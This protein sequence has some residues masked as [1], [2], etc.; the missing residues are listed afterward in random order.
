MTSTSSDYDTNMITLTRHTLNNQHKH[1]EANGD[2][3]LL[4]ASVQLGC[5]FVATMVRKAGLA[6]LY[7]NG[8][9]SKHE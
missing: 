5:K 6:N 2:L 4:L 3:T 8:Q 1:E 7:V 9:A